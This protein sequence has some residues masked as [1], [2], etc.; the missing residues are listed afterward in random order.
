LPEKNF[1]V[2][3]RLAVRTIESAEPT[4]FTSLKYPGGRPASANR[5][6]PRYYLR[7][8][9]SPACAKGLHFN[10]YFRVTT[11]SGGRP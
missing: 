3:V 11:R 2:A 4:A 5:P 10:R 8:P 1:A 9:A 6:A 7:P